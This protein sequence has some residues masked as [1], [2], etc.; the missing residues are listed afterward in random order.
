MILGFFPSRAMAE[1]MAARSTNSG[2][3]VKSC[4]TMRAT[5]KG[6]SCGARGVGLPLRQFAD[7]GFADFLAV[8]IAQHRFQD[9]TDGD[10]QPG[11][12]ADAGL[13]QGGERVKR[14]GPAVA[15]VELPERIKKIMCSVHGLRCMDCPRCQADVRK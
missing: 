11:N 1:R 6:I 13:F 7:V 15:G 2:T 12:R 9:Q 8:A 3:P 14:A 10:G 5:M 4:K